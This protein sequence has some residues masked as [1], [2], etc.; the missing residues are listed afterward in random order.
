MNR[1]ARHAAIQA[2]YAMSLACG[3][4]IK[5]AAREGSIRLLAVGEDLTFREDCRLQRMGECPIWS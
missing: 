3:A 5:V 2:I 1:T 4:P